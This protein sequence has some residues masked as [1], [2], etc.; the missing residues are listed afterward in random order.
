MLIIIIAKNLQ[1]NRGRMFKVLSDKCEVPWTIY[2]GA[3]C[4]NKR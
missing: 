3:K 4:Q 1:K 2:N